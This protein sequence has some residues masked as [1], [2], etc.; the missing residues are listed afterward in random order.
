MFVFKYVYSQIC[1]FTKYVYSQIC[2]FT[3]Y[4]YSQICLFTKYVSDLISSTFGLETC[5]FIAR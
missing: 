1:L 2:L 4:V 3:K 5:I